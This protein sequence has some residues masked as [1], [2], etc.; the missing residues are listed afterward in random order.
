MRSKVL[1]IPLIIGG[2]EVFSGETGQVVIPHEHAHVLAKYHKAKPEHVKM[3]IDASLEARKTWA[4]M[5]MDERLAIFM[6][7][8]D[9]LAAPTWRARINAAT[10]LGQGK[11]FFQAEI[12]SAC[13]LIDFLRFNVHYAA[14]MYDPQPVSSPGVWNRLTY[15]PLEGFVYAI[16]PFNFTA[17]GGNLTT[18]P[19]MLGNVVVWKP[20]DYAVLSNYYTYLLL[21]EAGLPDGVVNFIPGDPVSITQ[22]LLQDA[23]FAGIH[24]TGSTEVFRNIYKQIGDN[25]NKYRSY[26]RIVGE[27]GGKGFVFAHKSADLAAL[28]TALIRGAF[29]FAGQKCSAA[30]RAYIPKSVWPEL[31][32]RMFDQ[33]KEVKMG[34]PESVDVLVNAVIH[35]G[36]FERIKGYIEHAKKASD[37]EV[38]HG[39]KCDDSKGYFVEPTIILTSNPHYHS[40]VNE[41]FGPVLT[42]YV[43]DDDKYVETLQLCDSATQYSLTGSIFSQDREAILVAD[44][45]LENASGNYYINDKPTGAVV[46]QQPFGGAR[47]SGTN[48]KAGS[49]LNLL[50]WVNARTIKETFVPPH[51]VLYPY[52]R[53]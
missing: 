41:I 44:R 53:E 19:A 27:T 14:A 10:V 4:V 7:A 39:G 5:P 31:K 32:Q 28:S 21:K 20:S 34:N 16:T 23:N 24:Y 51:D 45:Y 47:G 2:K 17:I 11:N 48:D 22:L 6:K 43:Y 26:P 36:A 30:S 18:A 35:R 37:A 1:E 42:I 49:H 12:D 3:A 15:R 33:L 40:L 8:A 46:G 25:I 13:E 9:L 38:I 52:M 29:E 50:R